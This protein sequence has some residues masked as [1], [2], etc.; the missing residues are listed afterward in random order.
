M[1]TCTRVFGA[2]AESGELSTPS[3]R[4]R[5]AEESLFLVNRAEPAV[6][7]VLRLNIIEVLVR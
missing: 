2:G 6:A 3:H 1:G 4:F 5:L 7:L